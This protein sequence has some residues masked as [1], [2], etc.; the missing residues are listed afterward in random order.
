MAVLRVTQGGSFTYNT[1]WK[2][3]VQ[4]RVAVLYIIQ[5]DS[6]MYNTDSSFTYNTGCQSYVST[7]C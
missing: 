7:G 2:F 4:H 6:Y 1:G 5:D 3:Y